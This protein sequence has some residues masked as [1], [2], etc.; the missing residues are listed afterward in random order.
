M[1]N[2]G[3]LGRPIGGGGGPAG[4]TQGGSTGLS[5]GAA[6]LTGTHQADANEYKESGEHGQGLGVSGG[7][8]L[9]LFST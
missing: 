6:A 7:V 3:D 1:S 9:S 2:I 4:L 5:G 8:S